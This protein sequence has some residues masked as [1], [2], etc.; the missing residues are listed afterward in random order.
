MQLIGLK[1]DFDKFKNNHPKF[2][3]FVT[4]LAQAGIHEGTILECKVLTPEGREMQ[5]N[6]KI[7]QD[8]LDLLQKIKE[9][10]QNA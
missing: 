10:S 7:T 8:D 1:N 9:M 4:A 5:A 2:I 6:I 3:Q